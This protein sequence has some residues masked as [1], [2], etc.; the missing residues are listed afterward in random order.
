MH[1]KTNTIHMTG[2][3]ANGRSSD[4]LLRLIELDITCELKK[5][6]EFFSKMCLNDA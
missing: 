2:R 3:Q 4:R 1:F 5:S 6:I